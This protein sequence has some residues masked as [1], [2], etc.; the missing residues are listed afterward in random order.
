MK[1]LII[2]CMFLV[3]IMLMVNTSLYANSCDVI[4]SQ[5]K[6]IEDSNGKVS[7]KVD[8]LERPGEIAITISY[9]GYL[10][11]EGMVN[12]YLS[13]NGVERDF[14]TL[15]EEDENRTQRIRIISFQPMTMTKGPNQIKKL[16]I[17]TAVDYLLFEKAPYY[18]Q[19]GDL[20][21][22]A[23][24]F[25]N[26]RWDGNDNNNDGNFVF[27]FKSPIKAFPQDHF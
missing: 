18:G 17:D 10:T 16:P 9:D 25:C 13:V 14:I 7:V 12:M 24:F 6:S 1:K 20:K 15:K 11:Q 2:K 3:I 21:I 5:T 27:S 4:S 19:F 26:S 23:K 8:W 22:E